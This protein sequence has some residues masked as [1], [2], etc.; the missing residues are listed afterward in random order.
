MPNYVHVVAR[1]FVNYSLA[2]VVHSWKSFTGKKAN[3][4]LGCQGAFWQREYYD[5]LIRNENEFQRAIQYVADNPVKAGLK[6]WPWV[7]VWRQDGPIVAGGTP[8]LQKP[9]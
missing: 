3:D 7:W 9:E 4:L 6:N 8:A 2:S 5:H 1:I